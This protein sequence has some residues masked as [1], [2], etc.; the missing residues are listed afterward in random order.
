MLIE[1]ADADSGHGVSEFY[2]SCAVR[3]AGLTK[4]SLVAVRPEGVA[5]GKVVGALEPS[6]PS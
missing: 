3:G 6:G 1:G 2:A 5:G 4:G